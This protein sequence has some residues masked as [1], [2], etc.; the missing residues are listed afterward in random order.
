MLLL[1]ARGPPNPI[2]RCV[3]IICNIHRVGAANLLKKH[4]RPDYSHWEYR[5]LNNT[6]RRQAGRS[7]AQ[8]C[9]SICISA[10]QLRRSRSHAP[11]GRVAA[12]GVSGGGGPAVALSPRGICCFRPVWSACRLQSPGTAWSACHLQVPCAWTLQPAQ[13]RLM[14]M[15]LPRCQPVR[16]SC[17]PRTPGSFCPCSP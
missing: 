13:I 16:P 10:T 15:L 1:L 2:A 7:S 11:C 4:P 14:R 9:G 3:D 12:H 6:H 17:V 8:C 5:A